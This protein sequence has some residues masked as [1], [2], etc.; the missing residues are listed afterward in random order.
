MFKAMSVLEG[1]VSHFSSFDFVQ[2]HAVKN[3]LFL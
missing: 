3:A 2:I 1:R